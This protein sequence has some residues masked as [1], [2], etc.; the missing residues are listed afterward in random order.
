[1]IYLIS[2][3]VQI[4]VIGKLLLDWFYMRSV[5]NSNRLEISVNLLKILKIT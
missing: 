3:L 4:W 2:D 5:N 1:M